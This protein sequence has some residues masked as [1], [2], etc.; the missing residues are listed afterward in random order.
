MKQ[1]NLLLLMW[2]LLW[3][4]WTFRIR[5]AEILSQKWTLG[6]NALAIFKLFGFGFGVFLSDRA[7][8]PGPGDVVQLYSTKHKIAPQP[9]FKFSQVKIKYCVVQKRASA[10]HL[11]VLTPGLEP[12][13]TK[14]RATPLNNTLM[15]CSVISWFYE[16]GVEICQNHDSLCIFLN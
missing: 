8:G 9:D 4:L 11:D 12:E 5:I 1:K 13:P 6:P 7:Y 10:E 14:H 16:H 2:T 15:H 3:N